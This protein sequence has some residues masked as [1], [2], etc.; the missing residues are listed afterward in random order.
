MAP[1]GYEGATVD[2]PE[3]DFRG[4]GPHSGVAGKSAF[5]LQ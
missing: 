1:P 3:D 2:S 4:A 5:T